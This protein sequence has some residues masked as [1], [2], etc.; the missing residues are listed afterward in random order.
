MADM[1]KRVSDF[2]ASQL[3]PGESVVAAF[4]AN[5]KGTTS[6]TMLGGAAGLAV[7]AAVRKKKNAADESAIPLSSGMLVGLTQRRILLIRCG[8]LWGR[9]KAMLASLPLE[10][11]NSVEFE[12]GKIRC[13]VTLTVADAPP[14][15]LETKDYGKRA[16]TFAS[17]FAE[18][19]HGRKPTET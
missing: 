10:R 7:K 15:V 2:A 14:V 16:S 9:P 19:R 3:E 11:V 1:I 12:P 13:K 17:L 6:A 5:P 8:G 18:L 4:P